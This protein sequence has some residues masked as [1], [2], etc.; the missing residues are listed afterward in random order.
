MAGRQRYY[1]QER[2]NPQLGASYSAM[3]Q[4]PWSEAKK[5]EETLYGHNDMIGYPSRKQY[6]A[7]IKELES[8]G[9]KV[10]SQVN[11]I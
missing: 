3:G 5:Y 8:M 9:H 11:A 2:W 4:M 6:E 1:I 10:H 7:R